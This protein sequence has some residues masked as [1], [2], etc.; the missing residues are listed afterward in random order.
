MTKGIRAVSKDKK[1]V[2]LRREHI[3]RR[4]ATIFIKK[5]YDQTGVREIAAACN[6]SMGALY[7]YVGSK[8][9]ILFLVIQ[10]CT[11]G[12]K[13]FHLKV[14]TKFS[15]MSPTQGLREAIGF[16]CTLVDSTDK[17]VLFAYLETKRLPEKY[18]EAALTA[19]L[20]V[21]LKFEELLSRGCK[22]GEFRIA[23]VKMVA[24]SITTLCEIWA[25]RRRFLGKAVTLQDYINEQT[26]N[27]LRAIVKHD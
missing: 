21:M 19:E 11:S 3:A 4:A 18:R 17:A 27:I 1:L 20:D 26:D 24:L 9:D 8:E 5:G 25:T 6:M 12:F 14:V 10:Y 16:Y 15:H 2:A 23:N 22:T 7:N 13:D